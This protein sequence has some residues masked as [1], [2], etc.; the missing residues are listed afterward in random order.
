MKIKLPVLYFVLTLFCQR[1]PTND[2]LPKFEIVGIFFFRKQ[3]M[4]FHDL[5]VGWRRAAK[6]IMPKE[7]D[8]APDDPKPILCWS[9]AGEGIVPG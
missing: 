2:I 1:F 3:S 7:A 8:G 9:G 5:L 6:C 4:I